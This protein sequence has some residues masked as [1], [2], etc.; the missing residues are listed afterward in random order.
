M[1]F[2]KGRLCCINDIEA[3]SPL[4]L[5]S[6]GPAESPLIDDFLHPLVPILTQSSPHSGYLLLQTETLFYVQGLFAFYSLLDFKCW[7]D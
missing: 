1:D 3:L 7:V 2:S 5:L 4:L 6:E